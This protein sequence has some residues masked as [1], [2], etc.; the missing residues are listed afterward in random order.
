[1]KTTGRRRDR[2]YAYEAYLSTLTG[3]D[4]LDRET[5]FPRA[6]GDVNDHFGDALRRRGD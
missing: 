3:D 4:A 1:M 2:V 6:G 5:R